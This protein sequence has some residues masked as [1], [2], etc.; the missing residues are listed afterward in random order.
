MGSQ[1]TPIIFT[2]VG[3]TT[4]TLDGHPGVSFVDAAG[5]QVGESA[6]RVGG[7][8][9]T[10]TLAPGDQAYALMN[11]HDPGLFEGCAPAPTTSLKVYPPD[12]YDAI[13]IPFASSL[14]TAPLSQPELTIDVV[15]PG[16]GPA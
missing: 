3:A 2:N 13:T 5:N 9:P 6:T 8:T 10:V 15:A 16:S 11:Y 1:Y 12:E 7:S 4:C 14:C